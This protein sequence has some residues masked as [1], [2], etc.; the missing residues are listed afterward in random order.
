VK[1]GE[2]A[3]KN[4]RMGAMPGTP[5]VGEWDRAHDILDEARNIAE[6]RGVPV[7]QV[8]M[9]WLLAKPW[10]TSVLIG[11]RNEAQ[12][13]DNLGCSAWTLSGEE[14]AQLDA[15]SAPALPYP[16]WTQRSHAERNPPLTDASVLQRFAS[17][18]KS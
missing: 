11:A 8:A 10:V 17:P 4:I 7:G 16:Y 2:E 5:K 13:E 15:I 14:V 18:E 12:L 9:N 1:R 3:P 6:T